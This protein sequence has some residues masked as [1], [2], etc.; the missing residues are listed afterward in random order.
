MGILKKKNDC[1]DL[2]YF[3]EEACIK[4]RAVWMFASYAGD[5][6][7]SRR[8]TNVSKKISS[9]TEFGGHFEDGI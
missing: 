2:P 1:R 7:Q 9:S 5:L 3:M 4:S 8:L 6:T